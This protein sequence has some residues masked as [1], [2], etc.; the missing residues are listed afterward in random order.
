M[1]WLVD[2]AVDRAPEVLEERPVKAV[3]DVA[4]PKILVENIFAF[5]RS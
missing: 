4:D 5:A 2:A 1:I 3:I